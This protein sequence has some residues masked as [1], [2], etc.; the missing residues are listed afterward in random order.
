M[1]C[2]FGRLSQK[3]AD[4]WWACRLGAFVPANADTRPGSRSGDRAVRSLHRSAKPRRAALPVAA[5]L[6]VLLAACAQYENNRGVEVTW[7]PAAAGQLVRG[8]TTRQ[9]VLERLGPPSQVIALG[10]ETVLYYL[11]ERSRGNGLILVLYNRMRIDT[12]YDR[13]ILFFDADDRLT[14]FATQ[15]GERE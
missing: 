4:V 15:V 10:D 1:R 2:R 5:L 9:E 11:F 3:V 8:E 12:R 6:P 13:A 14:E 7:E